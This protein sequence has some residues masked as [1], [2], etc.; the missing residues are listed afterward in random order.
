VQ[1]L[2]EAGFLTGTN[3]SGGTEYDYFIRLRLTEKGRRAVGQWPP[4][5]VEAF[6]AELDR[7]IVREHDPDKKSKLQRWRDAA[8]DAGPQS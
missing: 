8:A 4:G 7:H 1:A 6:L 3:A 2:L 5:A